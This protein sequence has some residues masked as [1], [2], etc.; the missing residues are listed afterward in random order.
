MFIQYYRYAKK[1]HVQHIKEDKRL[2]IIYPADDHGA[3]TAE[4][5]FYVIGRIKGVEVAP[6]A[7]LEVKLVECRGRKTVRTVT[8]H[9]KD[10]QEGICVTY[11]GMVTDEPEEVIRGSGM[12]DL[13]YDPA[14]PETLWDTWNKAYY[15]DQYFTALIYGGTCQRN[16]INQT[17]QY[18]VELEPLKEGIYELHVSLDNGDEIISS[19]KTLQLATGHKEII[20]SRFSPDIH[21]NMV[22]QFAARE[23]FEAFT[24]PYAGIWDTRQFMMDWPVM[25]YIELPARWHFGDAQE[26]QSGTV[27]FFNYNISETC[28][29]YEVEL[30]SM[31]AGDQSCVDNPQRLLTYYYRTGNPEE[32][33]KEIKSGTF[34]VLPSHKYIAVTERKLEYRDAGWYLS[35][36]AVCKTLPSAVNKVLEDGCYYRIENRIVYLDYCFKETENAVPHSA[37]IRLGAGVYA[38][39]NLVLQVQN[40]VPIDPQWY[41][42][43][44][45]VQIMA[46]DREE[47]VRDKVIFKLDIPEV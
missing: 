41:G 23:G 39:E 20:L 30:P 47:T 36:Q 9:I 16:K 15:T 37:P 27:H 21:V 32:G 25:A 13:V 46:V 7:R 45:W 24:N 29:S 31:L 17:D 12:P 1:Y 5:D 34:G 40:E 18:G 14:M 11:P 3:M 22:R 42:R 33:L 19:A 8:A 38:E 35:L 6:N 2:Q 28:I 26:Y 10:N 43:E 44:V 4:H